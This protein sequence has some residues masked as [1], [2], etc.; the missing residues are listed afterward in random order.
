MTFKGVVA[1][2]GRVRG[3][4]GGRGHLVVAHILNDE[5]RLLRALGKLSEN[6]ANFELAYFLV[7]KT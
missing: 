2:E 4:F 7:F 5:D 6:V 1:S 3:Q